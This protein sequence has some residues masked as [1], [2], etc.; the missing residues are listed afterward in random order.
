VESDLEE[1]LSQAILR[2]Q[3]VDNT[4]VAVSVVKDE[5]LWFHSGYG[6]RQ[7]GG[8]SA[9]VTSSTSFG[10]GSISKPFT[11]LAWAI[12]TENGGPDLRRPISEY[13][14]G[15]V[16]KDRANTK[17]ITVHDILAQRTGLPRHDVLWYIGGY[18]ADEL[19]E[20]LRHLDPGILEKFRGDGCYNNLMYTAAGRLLGRSVGGSWE[21]YVKR[22]ILDPLEMKDTTFTI[23]ALKNAREYA[24]PCLKDTEMVPKD[25]SNIAAAGAINSNALDMAKWMQLF[26]RCGVT[27]KGEVLLSSGAVDKLFHRE[28]PIEWRRQHIHYGLGWFVSTRGQYGVLH[29]TGSTDG[30]SAIVVLVPEVKLGI[31]VLT[32]QHASYLPDRVA[33]AALEVVLGPAGGWRKWR[34]SKKSRRGLSD[35]TLSWLPSLPTP[36]SNGDRYA[37]NYKDLGYGEMTICNEG[38]HRW[39]RWTDNRWRLRR[40]L[41]WFLPLFYFW[42]E[43]FGQRQIVPIWIRGERNGGKSF[44]IRLEPEVSRIRF[45]RS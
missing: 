44:A 33:E 6:H 2:H 37:G 8:S 7:R 29:H 20:R 3:P 32:N 41:P 19:V 11:S 25:V 15:I 1:R 22:E 16:L 14:D 43:G 28:T 4:G 5:E 26:L 36:P 38:G 27:H 23:E 45:Y 13:D 17:K 10:I 31:C 18:H 35:W 9:P 40:A 39:L 21:D 12:H 42:I 24:V 30:Y 34:I